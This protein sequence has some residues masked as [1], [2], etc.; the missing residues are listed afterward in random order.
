M[1]M[2][3]QQIIDII[4]MLVGYAIS[5]FTEIKRNI[6]VLS[7]IVYGMEIANPKIATFLYPLIIVKL[8][9]FCVYHKTFIIDI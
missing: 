8:H 2:K 7:I 4:L 1:V 3:R 6:M 9:S 5:E